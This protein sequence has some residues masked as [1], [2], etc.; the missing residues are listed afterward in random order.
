MR[1]LVSKICTAPTDGTSAVTDAGWSATDGGWRVTDGGWRVTNGGWR[2]GATRP[3]PGVLTCPLKNLLLRRSLSSLSTP[4]CRSRSTSCKP[5]S[6]VGCGS[7]APSCRKRAA[8]AYR[9]PPGARPAGIARSRPSPMGSRVWPSHRACPLPPGPSVTPRTALRLE[10]GSP[11][12]RAMSGGALGTAASVLGVG[13][14]GELRLKGGV[15]GGAESGCQRLPAVAKAV[16]RPFLAASQSRSKV[17][18][19]PFWGAWGT[20]GISIRS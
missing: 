20:G 8:S 19:P 11:T 18:S 2:Q 4:A 14:A 15:R 13:G 6:P 7:A 3:R 12:R 10:G 16:G 1:L 17:Y 9:S 5:A